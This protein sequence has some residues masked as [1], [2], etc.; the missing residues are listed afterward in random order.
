MD[1]IAL[2]DDLAD[3]LKKKFRRHHKTS[4]FYITVSKQKRRNLFVR[5]YLKLTGKT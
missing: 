1:P 2:P 4:D 5:L 3:E